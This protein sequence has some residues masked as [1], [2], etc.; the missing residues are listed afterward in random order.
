[1]VRVI[2]V[3]CMLLVGIVERLSMESSGVRVFGSWSY[4]VRSVGGVVFFMMFVIVV[5]VVMFFYVYI[6]MD[7]YFV[8]LVGYIFV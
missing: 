5:F 1:M 8:V 3:R 4:C 7:V 6:V 2:I